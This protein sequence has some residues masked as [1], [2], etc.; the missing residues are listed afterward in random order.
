MPLAYEKVRDSYLSHGY[1]MKKAKAIAA[2][3]WNKNNPKNTN[4]WNKEEKK[5]K[6]SK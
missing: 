1:S 5:P 4:P 6:A 2:A 3:W